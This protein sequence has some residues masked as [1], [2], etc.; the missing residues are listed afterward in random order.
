[1]RNIIEY[2]RFGNKNTRGRK[3]SDEHKAKLSTARKSRKPVYCVELD[4][5]FAGI[6]IAAKELSL[7]HGNISECCKGK[8]KTCGGYHFQY[9]KGELI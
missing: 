4:K 3:L 6:R 5:V 1:M 9:Y 2:I 7:Y 8:Y